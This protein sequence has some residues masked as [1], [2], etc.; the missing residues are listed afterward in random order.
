M[1]RALKISLVLTGTLFLGAQL[2]PR[3]HNDGGSAQTGAL[4]K[5]FPVPGSVGAILKRSCYDCHSNSTNYPW[6]AQIQPFRYMLDSHITSG[7]A[8]LNFDAFGTYTARKQ[9]SK[10]SAIAESLE[11]DSMPLSSYTLLHRDAILTEAEKTQL[12]NWVKQ[13]SDSL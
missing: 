4:T 8:E 12:M 7:K 10:L 1:K 6:Y 3:D 13:T 5:V 9:R 11:E 2:I